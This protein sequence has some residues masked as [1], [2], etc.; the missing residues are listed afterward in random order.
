[1][2][3]EVFYMSSVIFSGSC[4]FALWHFAIK[5]LMLDN[6]RDSVFVIRD[7]LYSLAKDGKIAYDSDAYRAVELF[8]NGVIRYAH[9]FSFSSFVLISFD[10][11]KA[12]ADASRPFETIVSKIAGVEDPAV[13]VQLQDMLGEVALLLPR[14]IAKSSVMF[15]LSSIVYY[16]FR[17]VSTRVEDSKRKAI[18]AF[19]SEAVR[20]AGSPLYVAA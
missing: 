20:E 5:E 16:A 2:N 7:R 14:Y 6:F 11:E 15:I 9:R 12:Y 10:E 18:E 19:E 4:I 1:M 13:R 3:S 8:L 17:S